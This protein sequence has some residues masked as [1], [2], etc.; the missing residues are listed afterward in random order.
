MGVG[1]LKFGLLGA[2]GGFEAL[3]ASEEDAR[4]TSLVLDDDGAAAS[5][6]SMEAEDWLSGASAASAGGVRLDGKE[7]A[8]GAP[9]VL[10][11]GASC[12][13]APV[14]CLLACASVAPCCCSVCPRA[15]GVSGSSFAIGSGC[16]VCLCSFESSIRSSAGVVS[17]EVDDL[18][19]SWSAMPVVLYER[20][21]VGEGVYWSMLPRLPKRRR[22]F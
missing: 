22:S 18:G 15:L 20:G 6:P 14:S 5:P 16:D 12:A 4:A 9:G 10:P 2:G 19:S 1:K 11:I 21:R 17:G 3:L 13:P 7:S 8:V